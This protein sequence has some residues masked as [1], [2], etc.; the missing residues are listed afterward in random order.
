MSGASWESVSVCTSSSPPNIAILLCI[1]SSYARNLSIGHFHFRPCAHNCPKYM[2]IK[3][4]VSEHASQAYPCTLADHTFQA[5]V[6]LDFQAI[7]PP[8]HDVHAGSF[9]LSLASSPVKGSVEGG[10][11]CC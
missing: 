9:H 2:V 5:S 10:V 3:F 8:G 4:Q 1:S 7:P 11:L 6:V